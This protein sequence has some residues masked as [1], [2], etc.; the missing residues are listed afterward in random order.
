MKILLVFF[1]F[2]ASL[3]CLFSVIAV[4]IESF[5][6]VTALFVES[7]TLRESSDNLFPVEFNLS[8]SVS[9][10]DLSDIYRLRLKL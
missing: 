10:L 7:A 2:L 6:L 5:A 8:A 1:C 4:F 3:F 9:D